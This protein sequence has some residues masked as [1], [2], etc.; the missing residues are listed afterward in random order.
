MSEVI[1]TC[2]SRERM[3]SATPLHMLSEN[4]A[5]FIEQVPTG[6]EE[7]AG[8]VGGVWVTDAGGWRR[9][10]SSWRVSSI[11]L[12]MRALR[13]HWSLFIRE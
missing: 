13:S 3:M 4:I 8:A 11:T 1:L 12:S 2:G 6:R 7:T 9:S 10:R 5:I